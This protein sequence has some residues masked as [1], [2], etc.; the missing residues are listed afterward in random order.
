M[1]LTRF[2]AQAHL[3]SGT[4]IPD[5]LD[6]LPLILTRVAMNRYTL[7][8]QALV[9]VCLAVVATEGEMD[10]SDLWALGND[11]RGLLNAFA[12]RRMLGKY[13]QDCLNLLAHRLQQCQ[14]GAATQGRGQ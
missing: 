11:A 12:M 5:E 4:P 14:D 6:P 2:L 8:S 1:K 9:R 7:E 10:E 13:G 3:R